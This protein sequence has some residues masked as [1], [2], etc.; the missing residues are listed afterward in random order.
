MVL[1]QPEIPPNTANVGR[2]CAGTGLSLHLIKPL[3]FELTDRYLSTP[4]FAYW[5]H[6]DL[7]VH[8]DFSE[9]EALAGDGRIWLFSSH[10]TTSYWDVSYG[11]DDVLVF[12]RETAGLPEDL[13]ARHKDGLITLPHN[14]NIR[15]VNLSNAV[16]V[17]VY[18]ALRQQ[19]N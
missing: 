1:F 9:V 14:G 8:D 15:S 2:L 4:E 10:A 3:G 17:A 16:S 5:K 18:E 19:Q 7:H 12:G 11:P 6:I 13:K